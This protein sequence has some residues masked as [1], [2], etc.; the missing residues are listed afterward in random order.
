MSTGRAPR[1]TA[2]VLLALTAVFGAGALT[3]SPAAAQPLPDGTDSAVSWLAGRFVDGNHLETVFGEDSFPDQG[4]TADAVLAFAGADVAGDA[5]AAA[6][7]WLADPAN[8]AGYVGDGTAE[9]YT[10]ALAK[11]ALVATVRGEDP[12]DFGG[13]DLIAR[14]QARQAASGRYAD[15]SAFGDFSNGITQAL[16]VLSLHRAGADA[17]A[18]A[19]YLAGQQCADGGFPLQLEQ[20]ACVSQADATGFAVQALLATGLTD[21]A[22]AA[23]DQLEAVQAPGGGFADTG[24]AGSAPN[25]NSTALAAQALRV[26]GRDEAA[27]A[28]VAFLES[29][30][31]DCSGAAADRGAVR[32]D[33]AGGGDTQRATAQ[34]LLGLAGVG[35]ADLSADGDDPATPSIDCAPP[36]STTTTTP[37]TSTTTSAAPT[38]GTSS[39]APTTTSAAPVVPPPGGS[40]PVTGAAP[41]PFLA[42]GGL[43]LLAGLALVLLARGRRLDAGQP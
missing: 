20:P 9:S 4:L 31:V 35:L 27:D 29:L 13:V 26:G 8:L 37:P 11:L 41:L 2:A 5:A 12:A 40:L 6:T 14:L 30:Q 18:G 19:A 42:V 17:T 24:Q 7:T 21:E 1:A 34:A 39:A 3:A 22:T 38:S 15:L 32:Y 36:S 10:G 23:L 28:A 43:L 33:E 16:A 25:A